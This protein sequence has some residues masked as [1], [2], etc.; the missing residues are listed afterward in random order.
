VAPGQT[1]KDD[2]SLVLACRRGDGSA[3]E[4]LIRRY[5][6]LI[7]SAPVAYRIPASEADEIFQRVAV[8]LFEKLDQLKR[9]ESL[10]AWLLT[11][12]RRECQAHLAGGRRWVAEDQAPDPAQDPPDVAGRLDAVRS[13]HV[14]ALALERLDETCR[15]LLGALYLEDPGPSYE[16][17]GE[18]LGRPVGSLGP[19]RARCLKKLRKLFVELGGVVP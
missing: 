6:R 1:Y 19:T 8:K 16:Q 12:A 7:Y 3:W 18:R 10:P 2:K 15:K 9:A 17:I 13:E 4:L 14:L 11:T 5:Q